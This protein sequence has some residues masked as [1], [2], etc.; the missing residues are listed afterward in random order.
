MKKSLGAKIL[1]GATPTWVIG[2]YDSEG[3]P[4]LMTAAWV[5]VCCGDPPCLAVSL[6]KAT[7]SHGNIT[8]QK[9]FTV[10]IPSA[11]HAKEADYVGIASGR[12]TDKWQTTGLTPVAGD[13]VNAPY[14]AEFPIAIECRLIH[15]FELG[16]HT[17]FVGEIVD[18]K[19]EES[20]FGADGLLD[21]ERADPFFFVPGSGDYYAIS[22]KVGKA[23]SLGAD[24]RV[25][26]KPRD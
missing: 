21:M 2:T 15:T 10:N 13:L 6:R 26:R 20:I 17:Q 18:A 23:F 11:I 8:A 19:A 9:A 3:R 24:L 7:Y 5:G 12:D 22:R 4:N 16:L 25:N 14:V 1:A